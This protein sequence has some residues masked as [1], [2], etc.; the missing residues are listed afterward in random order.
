MNQMGRSGR[1]GAAGGGFHQ[2]PIQVVQGVLEGIEHDRRGM[3]AALTER[4]Q[5]R[6]RGVR[7]I[8][9]GHEAG[10]ARPSLEGVHAPP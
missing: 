10:H 4:V 2:H 6:F 7:Q 9:D 8:A 1:I 5:Y 3:A